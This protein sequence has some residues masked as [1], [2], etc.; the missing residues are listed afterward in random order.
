MQTSYQDM[1]QESAAIAELEPEV[2]ILTLVLTILAGCTGG[3]DSADVLHGG[4]TCTVLVDGAWTM[5]GAAFGMGDEAMTATVTVDADACSFQLSGW[6]MAMDDLPS[7]GVLDGDAVQ[8]DGLNSRWRTCTG[9]ASDTM[10]AS[11]TCSDDG[12]AW[13]MAAVVEVG[14]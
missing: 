8:L 13:Q 4:D 3:T 2:R 12:A 1:T 6:S 9:T 14:G 10:N 5:T 11:G 7:G